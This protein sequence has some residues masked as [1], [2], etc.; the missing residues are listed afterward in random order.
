VNSV[1]KS[2][3]FVFDFSSVTSHLM[4]N[5]VLGLVASHIGIKDLI[6]TAVGVF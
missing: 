1:S 2:Y 5:E 3:I 6:Q 4:S